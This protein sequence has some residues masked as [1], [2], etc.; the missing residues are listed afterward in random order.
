VEARPSGCR[1][2]TKMSL[3]RDKQWEKVFP[4]GPPLRALCFGIN[5]YAHLDTL[6]NCERDAD[7]IAKG[8]RSLSDGRN[9]KCNA[10]LRTGPQLKDKE[11]MKTAV[12]DFLNEIDKDAPPR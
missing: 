3:P 11:A 12:I 6:S 10:K 8:V 4:R 1:V 9:G 7:E 2:P 5:Q